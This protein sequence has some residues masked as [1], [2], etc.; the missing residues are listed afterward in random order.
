MSLKFWNGWIFSLWGIYHLIWN[1]VNQ[2]R[3]LYPLR[4]NLPCLEFLVSRDSLKVPPSKIPGLGQNAFH[5]PR[6]SATLNRCSTELWARYSVQTEPDISIIP[7]QRRLR[8]RFTSSWGCQQIRTLKHFGYLIVLDPL[9][10]PISASST[11]LRQSSWLHLRRQYIKK[12]CDTNGD[13]PHYQELH[14]PGYHDPQDSI[15]RLHTKSRRDPWINHCQ[16]NLE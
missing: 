4:S 15:Y 1:I 12:Q 2:C 16:L 14:D 3:F 11:V 10:N 13:T 8:L 9:E 7:D 6:V 5:V